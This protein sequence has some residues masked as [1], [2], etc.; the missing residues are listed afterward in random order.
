[1]KHLIIA[2]LMLLPACGHASSK[3]RDALRRK[4]IAPAT[5]NGWARVPLDREAQKAFPE[6]WLSDAQGNRVPYLVER[7][8]LWQPR[9]LDLEKLAVGTDSK[10]RPTAEFVLKFP[11]GWQVREREQLKIDLELRGAAPWVCRV[12]VSRRLEGS[13]SINFQ[14][15]IPLHVF[16]LGDAGT[17]T[18]L[19]VPWDFKIYRITL[20]T[21]QGKA[22]AIKG[23]RVTATTEP[24]A[25]PEDA[26]VSPRLDALSR[27]QW[28]LSLDGPDRII[29]AEITLNPPVAPGSPR[30]VQI[31][32]PAP[33]E[34]DSEVNRER[35]VSSTGLLWNLPALETTS[36]RISLEPTT[37]DCLH[38]RL[39]EG[40][41]PSAVKLL[42]RRD[43]LLFPAEAGK[44]Y[45]LHM[46]GQVQ[47]APG[48][49][50]A[51]PDSSRGIYQRE[52]LMLGNSEPDPQGIAKAT[53]PLEGTKP[54]LPWIAGIAV[55]ALGFVALKLFKSES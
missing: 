12:E 50:S 4:A 49:L 34:R 1:M 3:D 31:V 48:N 46:G 29:G 28:K 5:T 10:G 30:S 25:R 33:G 38:L 11:Q 51:L 35:S 39:P 8:G 27:G 32:T 47:S 16:D 2:L 37:T 55:V 52:A 40:A 36:N 26:A 13:T 9:E 15:D 6:L 18:S 14:R 21:I 42:V 22:P 54:W 45:F 19:S 24:S 23:L 53:Q 17:R 43:V 44:S 7:D 41:I 20:N